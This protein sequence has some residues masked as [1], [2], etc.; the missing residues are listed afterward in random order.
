[1]QYELILVKFLVSAGMYEWPLTGLFGRSAL[2][3]A[4]GLIFGNL[5][6]ALICMSLLSQLLQLACG[7]GS[8]PL[9]QQLWR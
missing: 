9:A 1:M 7:G 8:R 4:S 3:G 2:T 6:G 5:H